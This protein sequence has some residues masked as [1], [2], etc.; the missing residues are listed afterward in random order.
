MST[1]DELRQIEEDLARLKAAVA[2]LRRQVG[3]MGATDAAERAAMLAL[4]DEQDG[5]ITDLEARRDELR[6]RVAEG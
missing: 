6:R 4:A 1:E 3:D 2:D 5:V